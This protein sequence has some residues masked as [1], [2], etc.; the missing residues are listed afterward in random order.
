MY[1]ALAEGRRR[2]L[3][4]IEDFESNFR[5]HDRILRLIARRDAASARRAV[6]D[7]L[8][9]AEDLLRKDL[10]EQDRLRDNIGKSQVALIPAGR[11][12]KP[13]KRN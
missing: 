4:L 12:A 7:D 2:T 5:R 3:P 11:S 9:Y 10:A 6:L 13:G 8:Q 1:G